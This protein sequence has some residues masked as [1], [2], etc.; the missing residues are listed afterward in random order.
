MSECTGATETCTAESGEC[1]YCS[2]RECPFSEPLHFH[3]DGCPA[4]DLPEPTINMPVEW[5]PIRGLVYPELRE[6]VI[7][8]LEEAV[9]LFAGIRD[10]SYSPD[11]FSDQPIQDVLAELKALRGDK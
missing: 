2:I 7:K 10:G 5:A 3:H 11:S 6:R 8:A 1:T 9:D 4:C